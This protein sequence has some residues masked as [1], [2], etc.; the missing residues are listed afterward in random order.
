[1]RR[2]LFA[3]TSAFSLL[4]CVAAAGVWARSYRAGEAWERGWR[5]S[6]SEVVQWGWEI[7]RGSVVLTRARLIVSPLNETTDALLKSK[8]AAR[9]ESVTPERDESPEG[10]LGGFGV[11]RQQ[12]VGPNV[13]I[14]W[15]EVFI[16]MWAAVVGFAI[17]PGAWV[18][19]AMGRVV[20]G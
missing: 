1:V 5:V 8:L 19:G 15:D 18:K 17:L 11:N 4:G 3:M 13:V 2:A 7:S 10:G 14:D 12:A 20:G 9:K 16:P 6:G